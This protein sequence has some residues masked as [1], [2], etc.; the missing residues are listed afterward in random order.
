MAAGRPHT[1]TGLGRGFI[2][3]GIV[4]TVAGLVLGFEDIVRV[5][6][7]LVLLAVGALLFARRPAP[8]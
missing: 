1:F 4:L 6:V 3:A 7:L 5:G 8:R 2:S